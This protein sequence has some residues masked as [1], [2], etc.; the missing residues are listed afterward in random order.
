MTQTIAEDEIVIKFKIAS[1]ESLFFFGRECIRNEFLVPHV[2]GEIA[3]WLCSAERE[4]ERSF[5]GVKIKG[6]L[7]LLMIPRDSLKSTFVSA[8]YPLWKIFKDPDMRILIDSETRDLSKMILKSIKSMIDNS[9]EFRAIAGDLNAS[10]KNFTWNLEQIRVATRKDFRAKEDSIETSGV[11]VS[12]TGRHYRLILMDDLHSPTNINTKEQIQKVINHIQTMM[13]LLEDGGELIIV[14]TPWADDD[15][16]S[17]VQSLKD[18]DGKPLFDIFRHSCYNDDGT[19]YYPERNSLS[20]LALKRA[21]MSPELFSSQYECDPVPE[22][23]APLKRSH[24]RW[25]EAKDIPADI[26]KFQM[27]DTIGDKKSDSGDY[28][29]TCT[30]GIA[31]E[32]NELGLVKLY[33]IDGF[34]GWLNTSQQI[35]AIINLY[36]KTRPLEFGIEKSGMNT[37]KVHIE[38]NLKAKGLFLLTA[39]LKPANRIKEQ[40]IL[41]FMPYSQ[42][43]MVFINKEANKEFVEEFL[44]EWTRFPKGKRNDC[45]DASAYI[46]D[47]MEKYPLLMQKKSAPYCHQ[48]GVFMG[49][50]SNQA[51][52]GS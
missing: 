10:D 31:P 19:A 23:I 4:R 42:N 6:K 12:I 3:N 40:R 22:A 7:C 17:W 49:N 21:T 44:Y 2:H 48:E 51:W 30:W 43:A 47:F 34:C 35:E 26:M 24:L 32:L 33:L 37:L 38:N 28:F 11:D 20:A 14:G 9:E 29:A 5:G 16:Y 1:E 18:D 52:L 45:L 50:K 27:C 39:E 46:F 25:I 15:A 13:P 41:Q 8:I 36:M